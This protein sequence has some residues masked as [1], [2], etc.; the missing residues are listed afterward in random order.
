MRPP[1]TQQPLPRAARLAI[2]GAFAAFGG[3]LLAWSWLQWPDL[4]VDF[5]RELYVPWRLT[6]GDRLHTDL[7]WFNGPLSVWWNALC[8]ILSFSIRLLIF[9]AP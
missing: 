9:H 5:G 8:F 3:A 7:S 2:L 4:Q 1:T 6:E